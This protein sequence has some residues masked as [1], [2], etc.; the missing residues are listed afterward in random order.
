M[1]LI[2]TLD[3]TQRIKLTELSTH[4]VQSR[5]EA[6]DELCLLYTSPSPR[7]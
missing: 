4:K 5:Q 1:D 7:D 2:T 6:L 3:V